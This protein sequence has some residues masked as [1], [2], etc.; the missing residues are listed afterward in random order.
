MIHAG[1]LSIQRVSK[2]PGRSDRCVGTGEPAAGVYFDL[3]EFGSVS[4]HLHHRQKREKKE[5][6]EDSIPG[7]MLVWFI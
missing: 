6:T 1:T 3:V 5:G 7:I 2:A 4:A